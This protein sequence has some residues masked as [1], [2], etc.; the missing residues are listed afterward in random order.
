MAKKE[1]NQPLP[2]LNESDK[3]LNLVQ[4]R[5]MKPIMNINDL[6]TPVLSGV[7]GIEQLE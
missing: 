1:N 7:E 3:R 2:M 4:D 6:N 5:R